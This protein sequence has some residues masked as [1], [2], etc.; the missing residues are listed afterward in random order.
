MERPFEIYWAALSS[1]G[2]IHRIY[3]KHNQVTGRRVVEHN[4]NRIA[5]ERLLCDV[6]SRHEIP[7]L[8]EGGA[9][10]AVTEIATV[11]IASCHMGTAYRYNLKVNNTPHA[12]WNTY[13]HKTARVVAFDISTLWRHP[14]RP[15]ELAF[16]TYTP[17][18]QK[19]FTGGSLRHQSS[20]TEDDQPPPLPKVRREMYGATWELANALPN[21][22]MDERSGT[23]H[24]F[25]LARGD[26][27][28]GRPVEPST[29]AD[30]EL[31]ADLV[32]EAFSLTA[33][34]HPQGRDAADTGSLGGASKS[35]E[36]PSG[37]NTTT[38]SFPCIVRFQ[39]LQAIV[40]ELTE[41][42]VIKSD[43]SLRTSSASLPRANPKGDDGAERKQARSSSP[44]F[45]RS[46]RKLILNS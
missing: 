9:R 3:L 21:F 6:G 22:P 18:H 1:N 37:Q 26:V 30:F 29:I 43:K 14:D 32:A 5:D 31:H 27:F 11:I 38:T 13:A 23:I 16:L 24:N 40:P 25:T 17:D 33:V 12:E 20:E 46:K 36:D 44:W 42:F 41:P 39:D 2:Q 7:L 35:C 10:K 19:I 8:L 28:L 4:G 45:W 34:R 15:H